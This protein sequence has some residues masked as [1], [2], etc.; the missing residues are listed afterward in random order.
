MNTTSGDQSGEILSKLFS[1]NDLEATKGWLEQEKEISE[2]PKENRR[3][4]A[5]FSLPAGGEV[6]L[7]DMSQA[8]NNPNIAVAYRK[9]HISRGRSPAGSILSPLEL[10]LAFSPDESPPEILS[11]HHDKLAY[12]GIFDSQPRK[13]AVPLWGA[14]DSDLPPE[15][16]PVDLCQGSFASNWSWFSMGHGVNN[17]HAAVALRWHN[18]SS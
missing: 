14:P 9:P 11:I 15:Y 3:V 13:L 18:T 16:G 7:L 1:F 4:V 8:Y 5:R 10:F 6:Q 17:Q 12:H 2:Y